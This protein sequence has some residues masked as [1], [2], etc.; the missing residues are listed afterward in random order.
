MKWWDDLWLSEGFATFMQYLGA[1]A[2][3][4][5]SIPRVPFSFHFKVC[6]N[7]LM[8]EVMLSKYLLGLTRMIDAV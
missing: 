6:I 2:A 8:F 5:G 7:D 1:S 3:T 4:G